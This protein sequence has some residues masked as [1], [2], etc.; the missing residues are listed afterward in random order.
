MEKREPSKTVGGN[1]NWCS[2]YG[3]QYGGSF[4]KTKSYHMK[5]QSPPEHI[6]RENSNLKRYMHPVFTIAKT[7]K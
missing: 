4:K 7:G 3:G 6:S 5:Q 1:I 2:H